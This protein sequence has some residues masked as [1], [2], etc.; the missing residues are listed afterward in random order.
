[1]N[2]VF[3]LFLYTNLNLDVIIHIY[4][5]ESVY[6]HIKTEHIRMENIVHTLKQS[7]KQCNTMIA[8]NT[9]LSTSKQLLKIKR[10]HETMTSSP[11]LG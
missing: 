6:T 10:V 1:M 4:G 2:S 3:Y 9:K 8:V 5:M 11:C 7:N